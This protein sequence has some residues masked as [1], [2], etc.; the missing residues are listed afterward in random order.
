MSDLKDTGTPTPRRTTFAKRT[1]DVGS[2]IPSPTK[3]QS[4]SAAGGLSKMPG[5]NRRQSS[6]THRV[7]S[8]GDMRPPSRQ[9]NNVQEGYDVNET[10]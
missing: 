8:M 4:L 6:G 7:E 1:S 10:F 9:L 2:A 5:M 3:R